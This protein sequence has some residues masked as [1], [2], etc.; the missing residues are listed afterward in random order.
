MFDDDLLIHIANQTNLYPRLHHFRR[1]TY[2][3]FDTNADEIRSFLGIFIATGHVS[4]PNLANYWEINTIFSQPDIAKGMSRNRFEQLCGQLHFNDNSLAP[5]HGTP[6]YDKIYKIRPV[7]DAICGKSKTLYNPG[8]N[9]SRCS[10]GEVQGKIINQTIP[11]LEANQAWVQGVIYLRQLK[12]LLRQ[13][14]CL[15]R[16]IR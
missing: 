5:A 14:C 12:W 8:K 11:A 3:W 13:F 4:L 9:F 6:G 10:Y 2:Q 15:H 16:K 1:A 7:L